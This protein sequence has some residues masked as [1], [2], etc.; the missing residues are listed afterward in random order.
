MKFIGI[1]DVTDLSDLGADDLTA[2]INAKFALMDIDDDAK[3]KV[4]DYIKDCLDKIAFL[5]KDGDNIHYIGITSIRDEFFHTRVL[6]FYNK[7]YD[8]ESLLKRLGITDIL[9]VS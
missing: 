3:L 7:K 2:M 4:K 5:H 6:T 8:Y 9:W 1:D